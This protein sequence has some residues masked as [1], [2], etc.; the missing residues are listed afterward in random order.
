MK[1]EYAT[2]YLFRGIG[3][4]TVLNLNAPSLNHLSLQR[5]LGALR[6]LL[7]AS[8]RPKLSVEAKNEN[9][10]AFDFGN[11]NGLII[12]G[13]CLKMV[14]DGAAT[15]YATYPQTRTRRTFEKIAPL[16]ENYRR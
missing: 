13:L 11:R 7:L 15:R 6:C 16:I 12:S 5:N 10:V 9:L 14:A 3:G 8:P 4:S 2:I 1:W